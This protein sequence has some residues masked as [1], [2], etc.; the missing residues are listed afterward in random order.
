MDTRTQVERFLCFEI[1]LTQEF[2]SQ[3]FV[4]VLPQ[5]SLTSVVLLSPRDLDR[6]GMEAEGG[7]LVVLRCP[8]QGKIESLLLQI[9]ILHSWLLIL[10]L[11]LIGLYQV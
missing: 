8:Q 10:P 9:K 6:F 4:L 7:G 3:G 2:E 5:L 11:T 1:E